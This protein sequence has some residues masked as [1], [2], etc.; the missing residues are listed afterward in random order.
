M[1]HYNK[2]HSILKNWIHFIHTR[3]SH[4]LCFMLYF[5]DLD[6]KMQIDFTRNLKCKVC[7]SVVF[8]EQR[9]SSPKY[10]VVNLPVSSSAQGCWVS[11]LGCRIPSTTVNQYVDTPAPGCQV[12]TPGSQIRLTPVD[13]HVQ[14]ST[15]GCQ[16][17]TNS[18]NQ[19]SRPFHHPRATSTP[20]AY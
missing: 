13:I 15:Q 6:Y 20:N 8:P 19:K 11:A 14:S 9:R 3:F 16:V 10:P 1:L 18:S 4:I 2:I 5:V 12:S 7:W 17:P